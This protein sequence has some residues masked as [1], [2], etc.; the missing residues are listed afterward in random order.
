MTALSSDTDARQAPRS[1]WR[2]PA[3]LILWAGQG[4]SSVGTQASTLAL[5][6]L[7]LAITGSPAEAGILGGLRGL[8]YVLFG[9]PG[10]AMVDRWNRRLVMVVCDTGRALA[11]ASIPLTLWL[12]QLSA[13]QLYVVSFVEG[14]AFIFFGLAETAC[15]TRVVPPEQLPV[16]IAQSQATDATATLIGP[17]L[18]GL[19]YGIAQALPFVADAISYAISVLSVLLIRVPM[20][21]DRTDDR[22]PMRH[23]IAAGLRWLHRQSGLRSLWLLNSGINVVFGGWTLLVIVLAKRLG[24]NSNQIGLVF[25]S[26]GVALI[27]GSIVTPAVQRRFGVGAIM[28]AM[29]WMYAIFWPPYAFANSVLLLAIANAAGF[30]FVPISGGTQFSYRLLLVPDALQGRINSVFRLGAFGG[31]TLGFLLTGL[32]IQFYGPIA[33]V[34]LTFVPSVALALLPTLNRSLR[35]VGRLSDVATVE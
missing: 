19:L 15:L 30:F 32:L 5:P 27:L 11:F 22:R 33:T 9:L 6:L 16:A 4:V 35:S 34:W 18:G 26:G 12:G 23:E 8:A 13:A 7:I 14:I 17:P 24:A 25:A 29:T 10:G 2:N 1:L 28:V 20:Q 21:A 31:Q 3:Y